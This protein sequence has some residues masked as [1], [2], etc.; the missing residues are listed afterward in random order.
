[1][2][3]RAAT[4][5]MNFQMSDYKG[6]TPPVKSP[7]TKEEI[8]ELLFPR[9]REA[10]KEKRLTKEETRAAQEQHNNGYTPQ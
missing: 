6:S 1:M 2:F 5:R 9:V 7:R 3:L 8:N 10:S 4:E